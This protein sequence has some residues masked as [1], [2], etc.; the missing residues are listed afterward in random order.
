MAVSTLLSAGTSANP[1]SADITGRTPLS[2]AAQYGHMKV[3]QQLT[4]A[5]VDPDFKDKDG[6]T[7][8]WYALRYLPFEEKSNTVRHALLVFVV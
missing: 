8:L 6:R 4:D 3:V 2:Y 5:G 7:A 1:N